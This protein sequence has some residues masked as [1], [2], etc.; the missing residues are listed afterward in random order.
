MRGR[1]GFLSV[2]VSALLLSSAL[3]QTVNV[4]LT[5]S[6]NGVVS[7]DGNGILGSGTF[8]TRMTN[9]STLTN[10]V[11]DLGVPTNISIAD[12]SD[13]AMS[14]L[15]HETRRP[16]LIQT[17][18]FITAGIPNQLGP[19][20]RVSNL[21]PNTNYQVA[22]YTARITTSQT[23]SETSAT[24]NGQSKIGIATDASYVSLP[25]QEWFDYL[26]YTVNSGPAGQ[27][28]IIGTL[29]GLCGVQI[30][31]LELDALK[32]SLRMKISKLKKKIKKARA[33]APGKV[34]KLK[35][36]LRRLKKRLRRL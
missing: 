9:G 24:V 27:I 6:G 10:L 29:R 33:T 22:L 3:S 5:D 14:G 23:G 4:N 13:P 15:Y 19:T 8:W 26:L 34:R 12:E 17:Y 35:K 11:N 21:S 31:N 32:S 30:D 2:L 28:S 16:N 7:Q 1:T 36:K 20:L 25:G 18:G